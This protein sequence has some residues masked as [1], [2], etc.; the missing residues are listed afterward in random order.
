[1]KCP[2]GPQC[3]VCALPTSL[4]GQGLLD[5][6]AM[7]CSSP[8]IHSPGKETFLEP[9]LSEIQSSETFREPL[10]SVSL[11][12]SDQQGNSVD[13]SCNIT[14]SSDS[15][16]MTLLPDKS[17]TSSSPLSLSL[18]LTLECFMVEQSYEKL[19]R[20][21]AYYSDT[22]AQFEREIMLSKAPELAYR[23]KQTSETTGYYHTG[24]KASV[25]AKLH[26]LLQS[27][28]GIQLNRVQS[29]R[30][31]V[32]LIYT[33][34]VLAPPD[35]ISNHSAS[36]ITSHPWVLISSNNSFTSY[37]ATARSNMELSC[38]ILSSGNPKVWWI[39][40]DGS[41]IIASSNN[42]DGRLQVTAS[43]L[44]LQK[45]HLSDAGIYYCVAEVRRDIDVLP[46]RL[47]VEES[48]IPHSGELVG[49]PV[50]A[51]VGENVSLSCKMFGSP[52]PE[53]SWILP[54]GNILRRGLASSMG[55]MIQSNGSLSLLNPSPRDVG[56]YRCIGV[57]QYGSDSLSFP[58]KLNPKHIMPFEML[59][60]K[61]PQSA[62]GRSTKIRA[63]LFHQAGEG[64]GDDVEQ[65]EP[66]GP[67][68]NK[69]RP[70]LFE[71]HPQRRYRG[72]KVEQRG[73]M[74]E[75]PLR[76]GGRPVLATERRRNRFQNRN[77]GSTNRLRLDPQKWADLL[78]KIRQKTAN[79][80]S[81]QLTKGNPTAEPKQGNEDGGGI[82]D[83]TQNIGTETET[84]G[85]SEDDAVVQ[86][87]MSQP[88]QFPHAE[89]Q[90]NT[91]IK[92]HA[93]AETDVEMPTEKHIPP[94]N[95]ADTHTQTEKVNPVTKT[96]SIPIV[97]KTPSIPIKKNE[98][99]LP[100]SNSSKEI[101]LETKEGPK[102]GIYPRPGSSWPRQRLLPNAVPNSRNQSHWNLQR[103]LGKRRRLGWP[104][105]RPGTS[106]QPLPDVM[107]P[108]P[109]AVFP[110][111]RTSPTNL[112]QTVPT[113]TFM[114]VLL[115]TNQIDASNI[116]P[117]LYSQSYSPPG[118]SVSPTTDSTGPPL[119]PFA[120]N[121]STF[122][123]PVSQSSKTSQS[124]KS[125]L[126][127][128]QTP[129]LS[130]TVISEERVP[131]THDA[132]FTHGTLTHAETKS[133][134]AKSTEKPVST[135]SKDLEGDILDKSHFSTTHSFYAFSVPKES[136]KLPTARTIMRNTSTSP[137]RAS[138]DGSTSGSLTN[139]NIL[140]NSHRT[141][142]KS[143]FLSAS[144]NSVTP[145]TTFA[146]EP[147]SSDTTTITSTSTST[148]VTSSTPVFSTISTT[149]TIT[150]TLNPLD[151]MF[152]TT[153]DPANRKKDATVSFDISP[154]SSTAFST[155]SKKMT[156]IF[157]SSTSPLVIK[158]APLNTIEST[159]RGLSSTTITMTTTSPRS[160][161]RHF[162]EVDPRASPASVAPAWSQH[163]TDWKSSEA[164]SI[165]DSH[166]S[167]SPYPTSALH[168]AAP[169]VSPN[170]FK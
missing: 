81:S 96:P 34:R 165:P 85:S 61:G 29:S 75:G 17:V 33:T 12:L 119:S 106:P 156:T 89:P 51:T 18:S 46:L 137:K 116:D 123:D 139:E 118:T 28:I 107:R 147:L 67:A 45:V 93:D 41:K 80:S 21:L 7:L 36:S 30:H 66:R 62:S 82:R 53:I 9:E 42:V 84:E 113:T 122:T 50:M 131:D 24:V 151:D 157:S 74:R 39:L 121:R 87:K 164:N 56:H 154:G 78:A 138:Y 104:R 162:D 52:Q 32:Q 1:M 111:S 105:V 97:T 14:H 152:N 103:K 59:F 166:K 170:Q 132:T 22:A 38:P 54:D 150:S 31:K 68:N 71:S 47:A 44:L 83:R 110:D 161:S 11:G 148:S 20:I 27:A 142:T 153:S 101:V 86:D 99:I 167:R 120:I 40:P 109:Q 6:P 73:P 5:Q 100:H 64:S 65:E 43:G 55:L 37:V 125:T 2:N 4:Q 94:K 115:T 49:P 133:A 159:Q 140:S 79:I 135:H 57:N 13:L 16:E 143:P 63:P 136:S 98:T 155:I 128:K 163:P 10:G 70:V 160:S 126:N 145:T 48:S 108:R 91:E 124:K 26:W 88:V 23:Y 76:R 129:T 146:I 114:P 15:Q 141:T 168:P 60:P 127:K 130:K 158:T 117:S 92:T 144:N 35:L 19:W 58:L 90:I 8:V 112:L 25:K 69:E 169:L 72:E 149:G 77:R 95:E 3:P 102:Q 134:S